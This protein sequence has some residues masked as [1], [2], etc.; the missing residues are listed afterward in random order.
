VNSGTIQRRRTSTTRQEV[1]KWIDRRAKQEEAAQ[2]AVGR[3]AVNVLSI[4]MDRLE[5]LER[6][7]LPHDGAIDK[8]IHFW[9]LQ[10]RIIGS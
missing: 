4:L 5:Y 2:I 3:E 10:R 7:E 8:V 6:I 9:E 1:E